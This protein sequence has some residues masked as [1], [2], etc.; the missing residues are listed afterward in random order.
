MATQPN[1]VGFGLQN[2]IAPDLQVQ[3]QQLARQQALAD[4]LRQQSITP[5]EGQTVTGAGPARVVPISPWQGLAKLGQAYFAGQM[6]DE[7]DQK[8]TAL[9]QE[10]RQRT[11]DMLNG[12]NGDLSSRPAPGQLGSGMTGDIT[13]PSVG[14]PQIN[15]G[16]TNAAPIQQ[17]APQVDLSKAPIQSTGAAQA[18]SPDRF[19]LANLLRGSVIEQMGGAPAASAYWDQ[20]KLPDAVKTNNYYGLSQGEIADAMR[21][22]NANKGNTL[23]RED[24]TLTRTNPDGSITPVF[25]APSIK[26]GANIT[27]NNGQPQAAEIPGLAGIK[28]NMARAA[29]AGEGSVLPYNGF[30]ANGNPLPVTNRTQAATQGQ[31]QQSNTAPPTN[32]GFP[33]AMVVQGN[34]QNTNDTMEILKQER[35]EIAAR[36]DNDPR[37]AGDLQAI[38][39]EITG[40]Q[41]RLGQN[42]ASGM[43]PPGSQ[44]YGSQ[45]PGVTANADAQ[46]RGQVESMQ[47]SYKALQTVRSGGNMA[48]ED[49]DKMIGLASGK[50]PLTAG[51]R[52]ASMAAI[53]SPSAAEYEK[54]RD[55]LVNNLSGQ[56]GMSTDAARAMVYGSIPA[57]GA[58]KEAIANGLQTLKNQVQMRMIKA[59]YL[60]G[61][62]GSGDPK[63]YNQL[64]NQFDQNIS[65]KL[66][67]VITMPP[68]PARAQALK[69]AAQNPQVRAR[70][71]WAAQNGVLK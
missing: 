60:T 27:W 63:K 42:P 44:I 54:S 69:D 14:S 17:T 59:D 33:A 50:Y 39:R 51:T 11:I 30:D 9:N 3:Q 49:I 36:P 25:T 61:A 35:Q 48:L 46:A 38:D 70:L 6:Q 66:A 67:G 22:E 8:Q 29:A 7:N 26:T 12:G 43:Q 18:A 45:G 23:V 13:P 31:P 47:N 68:G 21:R 5:I 10:M 55:N 58:P 64:E 41:K 57:Y 20:F 65:P 71:E 15:L 24:S 56:L 4:A 53:F 40:W 28:Q 1:Q 34:G 19:A 16:D 32:A 52:A 62:Y 37:K 2:L